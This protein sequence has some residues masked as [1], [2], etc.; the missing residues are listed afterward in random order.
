MLS[1]FLTSLSKRNSSDVVYNQYQD[2]AVLNN[3]K[4]YFE[5]LLRNRNKFLL[6]G[7]A[8]GYRG[9]RITGIPFTSGDVVLHSEHKM[10]K[11]IRDQ[12]KLSQVVSEPT[13]TILWNFLGDNKPVPILW[14]AFP[15]HPHK[16]G[17]P[18]SNR[19]PN[20]MEI[21]EGMLYL[22]LVY[23]LFRPKVLCG[24][25][26]VGETVLNKILP[27]E[28]ITYIRHPSRG[29]KKRFISGMKKIL[30]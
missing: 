22:R 24:L 25:G 11:W 8:P 15:F 18:E 30:S 20:R 21:E 10:L 28:E 23:N 26:R 9:C 1:H 29:G 14:N 17:L 4:L 12:I 5:Y 7:E 3:L 19:V 27:E 2:K 13:A 6:V 16:K